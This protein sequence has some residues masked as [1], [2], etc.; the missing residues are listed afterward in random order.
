MSEQER[1]RPAFRVWK[2][3]QDIAHKHASTL[4][5]TREPKT[6]EMSASDYINSQAKQ[7]GQH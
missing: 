7:E 4:G 1:E 2:T 3:T 6:L 5:L